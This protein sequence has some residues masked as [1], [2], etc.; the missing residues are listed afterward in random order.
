M[1]TVQY[2]RL[3]V[4]PGDRLLDLGCGAGRHAF[5]ALRRGARVVALD[6]DAAEVKDAAAL[7]QAMIDEGEAGHLGDGAAAVGDALTLPFPDAAFDRIIAAEVLEHVPADRAAMAELARVLR[8]G[9]TLAVTV[10]RWFPELVNWALSDDYH[11]NPGG[12]IRIYR[13]SALVERLV[14]A[15]LE[16]YGSHHAH[17]LHTPYWWLKCAVGVRDDD[18][19][20]VQAYHRLLVWDITHSRSPLRMADRVL[21]P[22]IG[23]SLIVYLRKPSSS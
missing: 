17:A 11:N 9:G 19:R 13:R 10:P 1:L 23:K 8:P 2:E 5:E 3:G 4:R 14:A 21:N 18:H 16:P 15:G 7:L 20:A 6:A 22:I 12:H